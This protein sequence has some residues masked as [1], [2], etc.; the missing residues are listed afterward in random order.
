MIYLAKHN[1]LFLKPRKVAGTSFELALSIFSDHADDIIT[2]ISKD[3]ES[4][5]RVKPKNYNQKNFS[6]YNHISLDEIPLHLSTSKKIKKI[7]IIRHPFDSAISLY[8]WNTRKRPDPIEFFD[9]FKKNHKNLLTQNRQFYFTQNN[10]SI[11]YMIKYEQL[12][13]DISLLENVYTTLEGLEKHFQKFTAKSHIR[14]RN[15]IKLT[16]KQKLYIKQRFDII[17]DWEK[18]NFGYSLDDI[19]EFL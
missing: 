4:Q 8:F 14:K 13:T 1:I 2:P 17:C 6:F 15:N 7:S 3:D 10:Y 16:K 19:E 18:N 11:D 5:R 12:T 9:W